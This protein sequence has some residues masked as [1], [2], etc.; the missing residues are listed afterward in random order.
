MIKIAEA[1]ERQI[2]DWDEFVD[3]SINGT[4]FHL[5]TFLSYHKERFKDKERYLIVKNGDALFAQI[6]VTIE[7]LDGKRVA[8]SPYGASYGGFV[9]QSQPS[10]SKGREVIMAFIQYL[11]DNQVD[12]CVITPQIACCA[13]LSLDTFYFNM[14]EC[15]FRSINRDISSVVVFKENTPVETLVSSNAR[16][17]A[18]KGET[19]DIHIE[20]NAPLKD[21][22]QVLLSTYKKHNTN[23]THSYDEF[24]TLMTMLP[25][26][27]YVDVAYKGEIPIAGIGYFVYNPRVN[28]SF[29]LCQDIDYQKYQGLSL[30]VLSSL[31][32]CQEKGYQFFDF[33]TSSIN[34]MARENIFR[35]KEQYTKVGMFRETFDWT[36]NNK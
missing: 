33:G 15:G 13:D 2:Q 4:I 3:K 1:T 34:M 6:S 17:L 21:F 29:Y 32:N 18:H 23:P 16:N 25:D 26:R 5:R 31:K 22:W 20:R 36:N 9:F 8:K 24:E 27:V 12:R 35:F 14:L 28:S 30:L 10:Y 19:L 11:R 7:D